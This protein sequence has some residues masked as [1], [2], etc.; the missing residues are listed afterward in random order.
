MASVALVTHEGAAHIPAYLNALR[1]LDSVSEACVVDED[2][3][4][5]DQA[6]KVIGDK[7]TDT[8][9]SLT[10]M[11]RSREPVLTIVTATGRKAPSLIRPVLEAGIHVLAEK[12]ACVDPDDFANLSEL[13]DKKQVHLMLALG[14]RINPW[15]QDA[16]R[17]YQQNGIGNLYAVRGMTLADQTRIWNTERRNWTFNKSDAGGGHLIWLGTHQ[18]DLIL[19]LTGE[20]I[21]EVQAMAPNVGG[22]PI[23]VE[24]LA[25]LNFRM[26]SGAHGSLMSGYLLDHGYQIDTTI[27]G[28]KG[29]IR[30]GAG[31]RGELEWHGTDPAMNANPNRHFS[32]D[33]STAGYT[34]WVRETIR[35]ALGE[36]P[37]PITGAEGL[38]VL[39]AIF[40]AYESASTGQ[41]ITI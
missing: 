36:T 37:P 15:V 12:P 35:A 41:S 26:A 25:L 39:R 23:D 24:D 4:V 18:L 32:Y 40:A 10:D 7:L 33:S 1:D 9:Q 8:Y 28:S 17:I 2:G 5:F 30:H 11:L 38:D 34:P 21:T 16:R 29:W 3:A 19:F 14:N 6:R 31:D 27:W 20:R 22:G 13:A